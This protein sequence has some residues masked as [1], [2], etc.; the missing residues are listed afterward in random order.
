MTR[1]PGVHQAMRRGQDTLQPNWALDAMERMTLAAD[2]RILTF[3][4]RH[5]AYRSN[6]YTTRQISIALE[7][8]P[9]TV[10]ASTA[11]LSTQG[12]ILS[13]DGLHCSAE[14]ASRVRLPAK[15]AQAPRKSAA[16][17]LQKDSR[18]NSGNDVQDSESAPLN[19][20]RKEERKASYASGEPG[21]EMPARPPAAAPGLEPSHE[22][23]PALLIPS[24]VRSTGLATP[25]T[26]THPGG[27]ERGAGAA[28][29]DAQPDAVRFFGDLLGPAN[30][31]HFVM[32]NLYH[33]DRWLAEYSPAFI[34]LAWKF[35]PSV[36]G[37][38]RRSAGL[39]WLLNGEREWPEELRAQY[40]ADLQAERDRQRPAS[41]A[42]RVQIGDLL[43]WPDG[44]TATVQRLDR[45][46][47]VTDSEDDARG[48]VPFVLIGQGVEVLRS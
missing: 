21:I 7:L 9:R 29:P 26:D 14:A 48:Y 4:T 6:T 31:S 24:Q 12:L 16:S 22:E 38:R 17:P 40:E 32:S 47:V 45:A 23:A 27:G 10:Q 30:G 37:V 3:L 1:I 35:A 19:K 39:V 2:I 36:P 41:A 34:R 42:A 43:R 20:G 44:H 18:Q 28:L 46:Q 15:S 13:G 33:V 8:D 5:R 11:R 25:D